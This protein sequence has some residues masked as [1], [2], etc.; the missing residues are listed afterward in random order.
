MTH[1]PI[2]ALLTLAAAA[3]CAPRAP[4]AG[5]RL[6]TFT[7]AEY[8]FQG[9][10]TLAA[11]LTTLRLVNRGKELHHASI[12]KLGAGKT[13]A[14]FQAAMADVMSGKA[15]P[16]A[17]VSYAGG[18]NAI[19]PGDSSTVTEVLDPGNYLVLCLIP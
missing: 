2:L 19:D 18:P 9:P 6:A 10:D 12:F 3:A 1:R 5:A 15:P 14:D 7:A 11:G 8:A 16:P 4:D 17:W 13:L